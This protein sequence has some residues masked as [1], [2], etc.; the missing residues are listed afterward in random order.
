MNRVVQR[1]VNSFFGKSLLQHLKQGQVIIRADQPISHIYFL[2]QGYVKQH[3]ISEDGEEIAIH[4]FKPNSFFP[5]MLATVNKPNKYFFEAITEVKIYKTLAQDV[6]EFVKNE[7]VVLFDLTK[8]FAEGLNGLAQRIENLSTENAYKRIISL[9]LYLGSKF[10]QKDK[11]KV[12]I[13]LSLTH[14]DMASWVNL[15]RETTSR[16][17]E[18]LIRNGLISQN[19]KFFTIENH[20]KL[21]N[22]LK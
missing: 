18:K 8:R 15:T 1:K 16:Q 20:Q 10:G 2:K 22:L 12:L 5:M 9:L 4:I 13:I 21:K 19:Q 3:V 6:I 14:K 17:I 7:P 11:K